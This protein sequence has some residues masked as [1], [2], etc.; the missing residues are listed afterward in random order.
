MI[1]TLSLLLIADKASTAQ[2]SV[3]RAFLGACTVPKRELALT[4]TSSITVNS[5]SSSNSLLKGWLNRA[6]TF[7]SMNRISSPAAYSRTSRKLIPRPLKALWYSPVKRW[8]VSLLLFISSSRT[9]FNISAVVSIKVWVL[10]LIL[11]RSPVPH[12]R[13]P[14][15]LHK[16][17]RYDGVTHPWRSC[18]RPR[19]SHNRVC[20]ER[21]WPS[22]P[23]PVSFYLAD[24][25]H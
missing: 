14:P 4:S 5:R 9:F 15:R 7:Q 20:S 17:A 2:L 16:S 22:P 18:A 23:A 19:G 25:P 21:H 10:L 8:R 1:P 6:E 13:S 12:S 24:Y 3:I 11:H